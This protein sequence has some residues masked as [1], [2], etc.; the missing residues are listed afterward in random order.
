MCWHL[1][2]DVAMSAR[3][4]VKEESG[5]SNPGSSNS[6]LLIL[7]YILNMYRHL[8]ITFVNKLTII[9]RFTHF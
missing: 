9:N 8:N 2:L 3:L 7:K 5:G 4:H 1:I 6:F